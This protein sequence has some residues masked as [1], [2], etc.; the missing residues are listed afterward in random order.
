M[1]RRDRRVDELWGRL[2]ELLRE[3]E[4]LDTETVTEFRKKVSLRDLEGSPV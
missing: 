2:R 3:A 1:L 4:S